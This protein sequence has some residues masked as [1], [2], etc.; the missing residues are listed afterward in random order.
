MVKSIVGIVL[1]K[2]YTFSYEL[3]IGQWILKK[4]RIHLSYDI[5]S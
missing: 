4:V 3:I 2:K 5:A 1:S